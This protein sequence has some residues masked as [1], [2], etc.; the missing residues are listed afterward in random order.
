MN[1]EYE[2][3][4]RKIRSVLGRGAQRD[5]SLGMALIEMR[6]SGLWREVARKKDKPY[7]AFRSFLYGEFRIGVS[8]VM[9]CT[10]IAATFTRDQVVGL[11][12][13]NANLIAN[14]KKV[15]TRE[16]LLRAHPG[17]MSSGGV[18]LEAVVRRMPHGELFYPLKR[19]MRQAGTVTL[20]DVTSLMLNN[21]GVSVRIELFRGKF[22]ASILSRSS[23]LSIG[24][25]VTAPTAV[26]NAIQKYIKLK[27]A[28]ERRAA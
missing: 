10:R 23:V 5:W 8:E 26:G 19:R 9:R 11:S 14:V 16:E 6:D 12:S 13:Y 21:P 24:I 17:G 15:K 3:L 4:C 18:S 1:K 2:R 28:S 20:V 22:K 25:D 27:M 7:Q